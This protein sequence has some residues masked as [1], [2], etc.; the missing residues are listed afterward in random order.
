MDPYEKVACGGMD[1]HYKFSRVTFRDR[2]LGVVRRERLDHANRDELLRHLSRWPRDVPIVLEASFGWGWISDMML[3]AGLNPQLSNCYKVEQMRKARGWAKSN[4]KDGDLTSLLPAEPEEWWRVW[5]A[6]AAVRDRREWVRYRADLVREQTAV[7]NRIHAIMHRHGIIYECSD[8][9]GAAGRRFLAELC[10]TGGGVL[11]GGALEA[12]RGQVQMW[13]HVRGRL[14][15]I[16]NRLRKELQTDE[17]VSRL[18]TIPG[19]GLILSHV[20]AAEIGDMGRFGSTKKLRSYTLLAPQADDSGQEDP[21]A[22]PIGRHVGTRGNRVLKWAFIEAAHG[23]VRKGGYWREVFNSYTEGGKKN[24]N[25]GYIKVAGLLV[26]VVRGVWLSGEPYQEQAPSRPGGVK[27]R[28]RGRRGRG[29]TRSG[30]GQPYRPMVDAASP[31]SRAAG[32][33]G[34]QK[35]D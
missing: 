5:M 8:L 11:S 23:A 2:G 15:G 19:V 34:S 32:Q 12:L 35:R 20:L 24:R 25:R 16:D 26:G 27:R 13:Q 22:V 10:R 17:L 29:G 3:K 1:V 28:R 31:S 14:A 21:E 9:F 18:K 33:A 7:K 6:P 30:T 4:R